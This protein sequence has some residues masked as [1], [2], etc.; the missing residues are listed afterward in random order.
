[1]IIKTELAYIGGPVYVAGSRRNKKA[2]AAARSYISSVFKD[3]PDLRE[4]V[5]P[6]YAFS[7]K[8]RV[9]SDEY[10][11]SLLNDNVELIPRPVSRVTEKGAVDVEGNEYDVDVLIIATGFTPWRY[12]AHL[13][14]FGREGSDLHEVWR[15]GA[16][17]FVGMTVPGFPNFYMMYGPNTNGGGAISIQWLAEQGAAWVLRDIARMRRRRYTLIDTKQSH[18]D[19][20][21]RWMQ[22][23]LQRTAWARA[24]NYM[25]AES[26]RLVT[27]FHGSMTLHWLL[28]HILHPL[29][30]FGERAQRAVGSSS[31]VGEA[32]RRVSEN[33]QRIRS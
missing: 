28:L 1:M 29:G 8:R 4:A 2:E 10:Y 27:Q 7:G 20:Y 33:A 12:L 31:A 21:N 32:T 18:A 15:E 25:R 3:R 30:T 17:A 11:P 19:R 6:K 22:K 26:G 14:V 5:T 24:N 23:R 16:F 9:L 13:R